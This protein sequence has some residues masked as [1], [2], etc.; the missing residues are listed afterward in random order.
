MAAGVTVLAASDATW[1]SAAAAVA[2][3]ATYL[4][5][6][7]AVGLGA[8]AKAVYELLRSPRRKRASSAAVEGDST[9]RA[10]SNEGST[11]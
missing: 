5:L 7:R 11:P 1:V 3:T 10:P 9:K 2:A 4:G 6:L 8:E